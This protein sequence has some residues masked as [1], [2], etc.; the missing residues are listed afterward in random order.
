MA[1]TISIGAEKGGVAK[2]T[3][4]AILSFLLSKVGKVLAIDFDAQGDLTLML[5]KKL[6]AEFKGN[7]VYQACV[8]GEAAPYIH[9]LKDSLHL[10]A[11]EDQLY[12][13]DSPYDALSKA[14]AASQSKY[15]YIIIDM[16]P[17]LGKQVICGLHASDFTICATLAE[18]F[19]YE[20]INSFLEL[21]ERSKGFVPQLQLA[22]ILITSFDPRTSIDSGYT[23]AIQHHYPS[24]VFKTII[25]KVAHVKKFAH[26][27][28]TDR[29]K[30][31]R[32]AL[33]PYQEL[34]K[35][36]IAIVSG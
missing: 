6:K 32:E 11:A 33:K 31:D 16:P 29:T 5:S 36:L 7:S 3:T 8:T 24:Q 34:L 27:G 23:Q 20:K 15:D 30:A 10:L 17:Q 14:L 9:K 21:V 28:V 19:S 2:T 18:P 13:F 26:Y 12:L 35:E 4:A 25:K 1:T 22:G